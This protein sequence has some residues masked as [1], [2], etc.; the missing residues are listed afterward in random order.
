MQIKPWEWDFDNYEGDAEHEDY[1]CL[2]PE[3]ISNIEQIEQFEQNRIKRENQVA[4]A[5]ARRNAA[6]RR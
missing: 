5:Q 6:G 3:D 1:R 4:K 2:F